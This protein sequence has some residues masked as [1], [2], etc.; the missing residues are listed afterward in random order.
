MIAIINENTLI[1]LYL[2]KTRRNNYT[3]LLRILSI[4]HNETIFKWLKNNIKTIIHLIILVEVKYKNDKVT[5][6]VYV[7]KVNYKDSIIDYTLY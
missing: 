7:Y 5:N 1:K 6:D 3:W 4:L 2:E